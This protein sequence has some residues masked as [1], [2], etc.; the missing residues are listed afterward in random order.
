MSLTR[1]TPLSRALAQWPDTWDED[2]FSDTMMAGTTNNLE[3]FETDNEVVVK[4]NVAGV[5]QDQI[6][7]TFE[8]GVLMIKAQS[9]EEDK[10]DKK[11]YVKSSWAYSYKVSVPGKVDYAAEPAAKLDHGILTISFKK[12]EQEKPRKVQIK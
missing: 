7:V 8:K 2:F 3:I 12:S 4:V 5:S 10:K 1:W 6:D 11:H 9:T